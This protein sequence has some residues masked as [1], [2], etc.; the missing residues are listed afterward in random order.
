MIPVDEVRRR[1][2]GIWRL[3]AARITARVARVVRDLG[4]AEEFAQD[5]L[6]AVMVES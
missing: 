4:L 6:V 1:L 5:A 2:D 3:E